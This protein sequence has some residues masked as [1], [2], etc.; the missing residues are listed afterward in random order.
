MIWVK[1]GEEMV[2]EKGQLLTELN[3]STKTSGGGL[4]TSFCR[5]DGDVKG[6][7]FSNRSQSPL[8]KLPHTPLTRLH[9]IL[10]ILL[11]T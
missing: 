9:F 4:F 6:Q 3:S 10:V 1:S 2:T 7:R 11:S 8:S 5:K